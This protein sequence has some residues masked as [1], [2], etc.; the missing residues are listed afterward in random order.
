DVPLALADREEQNV[1]RH[2]QLRGCALIA[3]TGFLHQAQPEP[4]RE[5]ACRSLLRRAVRRQRHRRRHQ[6]LL[7][8]QS[9]R[10]EGLLRSA[11]DLWTAHGVLVRMKW[12]SPLPLALLAFSCCAQDSTRAAS[13]LLVHVNPVA[14][15]RIRAHAG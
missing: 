6:E 11:A 9:R 14:L 12:L 2:A 5:R 7:R 8:L 3:G 1:L 10:G 13:S 4:A 15:E